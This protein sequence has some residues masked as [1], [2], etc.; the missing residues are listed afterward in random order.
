MREKLENSGCLLRECG[1][2]IMTE[3]KRFLHSIQGNV[4]TVT[5]DLHDAV[6]FYYESS[7]YELCLELQAQT[8][9]WFGV[10]EI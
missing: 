9:R 5:D 8:H 6:W 1:F 10:V 3:D 7:A 4:Y 2:A